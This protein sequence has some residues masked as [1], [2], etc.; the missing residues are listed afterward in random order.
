M[1]MAGYLRA[2]LL[3]WVG[4]LLVACQTAPE[5][6]PGT[7][8]LVRHAEKVTGS[9]GAVLE[10][11]KDPPLTAAGEARA[12]ALADRL[13][14]AGVTQVWST[15]TIRTRDTAAPLANRL[16]VS[17]QLYD[18]SDLP[19]FA[20]QL[21]AAANGAILVV[22]HSN[23]TP[24]LAEA[25]GAAPGAPIVEAVEYDRLY[26]INLDSGRGVIERFGAVSPMP[27]TDD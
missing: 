13:Q 23:T 5:P 4:L 26:V 17:V 27:E 1:T 22:G 8:Y 25:L 16:G 15:D 21:K 14:D 20:A 2:G 7:A 19:G 11:P 9:A 12:E 18:P 24:Q 6:A 10:N 3:A